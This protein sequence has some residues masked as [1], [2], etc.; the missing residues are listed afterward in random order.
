MS[1]AIVD[2]SQSL[3]DLNGEDILV[4]VSAGDEEE[5]SFTLG[6]ACISALMSD[7][8]GDDKKDGGEKYKL[9]QLAGKI[10]KDG[11]DVK[12]LTLNST[13]KKL[14]EDRAA[15]R[16][17]ILIYGRIYEALEGEREE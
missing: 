3:K 10:K 13:Q 14:I 1:K 8:E 4:Q 5:S 6:A 16:F 2:M 7:M 17:S 12:D 11:E 15:K 9:F